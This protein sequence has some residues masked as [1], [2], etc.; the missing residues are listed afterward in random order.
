MKSLI[1]SSYQDLTYFSIIAFET[2]GLGSG[3][4]DLGQYILSNMDPKERRE[5]EEELIRNYYE[6][7]VRLGVQNFS[8]EDC[9][10]EYKIGG[11]ERWLWFLVYFCAQEGPVMTKWAQFFHNQIKEFVHDHKIR[12]EDITQPRP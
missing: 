5:C 9:W 10:S 6:K 3:P 11:L 4:Q 12:P 8:W 2:T 7:L 1:T